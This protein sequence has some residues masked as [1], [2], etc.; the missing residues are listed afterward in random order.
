MAYSSGKLSLTPTLIII[1]T[2]CCGPHCRSGELSRMLPSEMALLAHGWPRK[3]SADGASGSEDEEYY[4][5][6]AQ[7]ARM[8]HRV[9]RAERMLLSYERTGWVDDIPARVTGAAGHGELGSFQGWR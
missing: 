1:L 5:P 2:S 6:G 4:L 3:G 8:L 7:S 9:R